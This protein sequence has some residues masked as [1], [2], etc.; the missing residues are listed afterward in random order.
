MYHAAPINRFYAPRLAIEPG[1]AELRIPVRPEFFHAASAAH[2]SVYFK[3]L[4]DAAFFA[5][6]SL[7]EDVLVLTA[8]FT[9]YLLAPVREGDLLARGTVGWES[10]SSLIAE[11]V[12]YDSHGSQIA[13]GSGSFVK[14]RIALDESIGYR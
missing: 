2:G 3:A 9:I 6:N 7:V 13:R 14:S 11:S 12:L 8:S 1:K 4:D 5:A 10:R